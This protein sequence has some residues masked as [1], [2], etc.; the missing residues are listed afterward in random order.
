MLLQINSL[1]K[2]FTSY[3]QYANAT[4]EDIFDKPALENAQ[5]LK[6][7]TVQSTVLENLG[8]GSF[9]LLPLPLLAQISSVNGILTED[10]IAWFYRYSFEWQFFPLPHPVWPQ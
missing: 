9:K 3:A 6:F 5:K 10:L 1:R 2:R 7:Q 4:I 8:G